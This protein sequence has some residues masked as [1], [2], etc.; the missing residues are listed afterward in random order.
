VK[1]QR[2][3]GNFPQAFTPLTLIEAAVAIAKAGSKAAA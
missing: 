3:V 1:R 2:R